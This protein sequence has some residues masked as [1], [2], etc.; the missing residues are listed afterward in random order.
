M[1]PGEIL[2]GEGPI[3]LYEGR[4]V[5]EIE[6]TNTSDHTIERAPGAC[7]STC[8][9]AIPCAGVPESVGA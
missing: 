5:A 1:K 2:F 3:V 8:P 7:T 4:R 6:V 9:P